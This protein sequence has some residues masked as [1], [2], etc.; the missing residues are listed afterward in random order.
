MAVLGAAILVW[1]V[2]SSAQEPISGEIAVLQ[3]LDKVTAR[4]STIRAELGRA[5]RFGTLIITVRKCLETPPEEPPEVSVFLEI[6]DL[7]QGMAPELVFSG[8]MF[9]SNPALSALEHAVYDVWALDCAS[10]STTDGAV[11]SANP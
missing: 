4:I 3:G 2:Q 10:F 1:A 5:V 8:W 6:F 9:A 7:R 11:L